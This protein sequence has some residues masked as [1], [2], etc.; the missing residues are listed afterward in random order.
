MVALVQN[1]DGKPVSLHR[2][3]LNGASKADIKSPKKIMPGTETINGAAIRL[4]PPGGMFDKDVLGV[5]E[6]IETAISV[7]QMF[8]VA[9]WAVLSASTMLHFRP[10]KSIRKI[11]IYG[12]CDPNFVGQHAAYELAMRLYNEGLIVDVALPEVGDWNDVLNNRIPDK[13]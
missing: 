11:M 2:T 6:G 10:P 12:D 7:S 8:R 5:A 9:T 3:Y 1:V 4:F 13:R